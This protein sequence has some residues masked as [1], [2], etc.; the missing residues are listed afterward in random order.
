M[1]SFCSRK[2]VFQH[3]ETLP[4]DTCFG[5]S[6]GHQLIEHVRKECKGDSEDVD[7]TVDVDE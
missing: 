6:V 4:A 7:C 2:P 1:L 3:E 5:F